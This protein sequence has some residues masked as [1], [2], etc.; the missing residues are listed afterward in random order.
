MLLARGIIT[1]GLRREAAQGAKRV[2]RL[3]SAAAR[4]AAIMQRGIVKAAIRRNVRLGSRYVGL[5]LNSRRFPMGT[6]QSGKCHNR[7][8]GRVFFPQRCSGEIA[9]I[10][11]WQSHGYGSKLLA[12]SGRERFDGLPELRWS[13]SRRE[14][15]LR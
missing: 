10:A 6:G 15:I 12:G 4:L 11:A 14:E 7:T 13:Q 5:P 1:E 3:R 2:A 9:Q 8:F